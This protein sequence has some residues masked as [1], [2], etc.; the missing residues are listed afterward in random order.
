MADVP[1]MSNPMT[2]SGDVIY[3]G[4]SGVPTRL[5]KGTDGQVLKLA[6]GVPS[7]DDEASGGIDSGTSFPGSPSTGDLFHRTDLG[8]ALWRYNGTNWLSAHQILMAGGASSDPA[9]LS[10][11]A[12]TARWPVWNQAMYLDDLKWTVFVSTTN[13]G[14]AYWT[15]DLQ[16]ATSANSTTSLGTLDTS[17]NSANTWYEKTLSVGAVLNSTAFMLKGRVAKT[18]SPG[19][20]TQTSILVWR[21]IAT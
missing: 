21:L 18:G 13:S 7:W 4:A 14:A 19:N 3:G 16:W 6:S 17:A 2:T 5:A 8:T 1:L 10:A 11:T 12:D 15:Y 9:G 20:V